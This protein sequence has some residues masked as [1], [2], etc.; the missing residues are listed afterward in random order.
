M[1]TALSLSLLA[2]V[3]GE[4][5]WVER[6]KYTRQNIDDNGATR[7]LGLEIEASY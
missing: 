1:E 3:S 7:R 6:A 2:C 4:K 5:R